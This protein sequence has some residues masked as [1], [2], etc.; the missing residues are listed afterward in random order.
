MKEMIE[1]LK[2]NKKIVC[3]GIAAAIC[4][5]LV[6]VLVLNKKGDN[7][8]QTPEST[9][10][11]NSQADADMEEGSKTSGKGDKAT[12]EN[13]TSG[14]SQAADEITTTVNKEET[15][16]TTVNTEAQGNVP[17]TPETAPAE[18]QKPAE[19]QAQQPTEAPTTVKPAEKPTTEA[20]LLEGGLLAD[21]PDG[22]ICDTPEVNEFNKHPTNGAAVFPFKLYDWEH[23][24]TYKYTNGNGNYVTYEG[25][26]ELDYAN[27]ELAYNYSLP[28]W[29]SMGYPDIYAYEDAVIAFYE[30][31]KEVGG[32]IWAG[33][34]GDV[35]GRV[36]FVPLRVI[37]Y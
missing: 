18:T 14:D 24:Y 2:S 34:Y 17:E 31:N 15:E 20:P 9:G 37:E 23:L 25:Y 11:V 8:I 26:Y 29:Q 6:L 7:G 21:T 10:N 32:A 1:K 36:Y 35:P 28:I 30:E 19:P 12:A 4:L 22:I 3:A 33:E 5:I 27:D 16:G 13:M